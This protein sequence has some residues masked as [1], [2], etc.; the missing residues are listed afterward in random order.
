MRPFSQFITNRNNLNSRR[1]RLQSSDASSFPSPGE[2]FPNWLKERKD[3]QET[4][5]NYED[6]DSLDICQICSKPASARSAYEAKALEIW[7]RKSYFFKGMG[8]NTRSSI[9]D[10]LKSKQ[11][12]Q[13][14]TII[15]SGELVQNMYMIVK[16]RI[17]VEKNG[18][19]V[20]IGPYN[21]IGERELMRSIEISQQITAKTLVDCV[22]LMKNDFDILA[23]KNRLKE[24]YSFKEKLKQLKCFADLRISKIEQLCSSMTIVQYSSNELIFDL[25]HTSSFFYYIR[26]GS[27]IVDLLI[28]LQKKNNWPTG[29]KMWQTLVTQEKYSRTIKEFSADE[30]FGER[31]VV[32][33][34]LRETK[35]IAKSD[36]TVLYLF[37]KDEMNEILNEREKESFL[38][39]SPR[40]LASPEVA[41]KLKSQIAEY[42]VKFAALMEASD[43]KRVKKGRALWDESIS[44][45]KDKYAKE[46]IF[47]HTRNMKNILKDKK[48]SISLSP[49]RTA[50]TFYKTF[51]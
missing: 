39:S 1:I 29:N 37:G 23:F 32:L 24:Q 17:L 46:L 27:V 49:R 5:K 28:T 7:A 41:K 43:I 36:R 50:A 48:F 6:I 30:I 8:K 42:K 31:E 22:Y 19:T 34:L 4:L 16:G 44:M 11:F 47:R 13:G 25:L 51:L 38:N 9:C 15:P 26:K 20:E 3:F 35:A 40:K 2:I 21:L 18:V 45:K 14:E 33:N 10:R 12:Q